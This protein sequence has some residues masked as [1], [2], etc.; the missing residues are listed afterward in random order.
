MNGT[1]KNMEV[2]TAA[3]T[4]TMQLKIPNNNTTL[5]IAIPREVVDARAGADGK[6]GDDMDFAVF[7]D[8]QNIA[9]DEY[10][11]MDGKWADRLRITDHPEKI[12]ILSIDLKQGIETLEIVGYW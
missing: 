10:S 3:N 1:I 9:S 2:D 7:A 8:E 4:L 12:R 5:Q 11:P 6:S